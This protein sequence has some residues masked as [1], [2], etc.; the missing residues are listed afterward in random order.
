[1]GTKHLLRWAGAWTCSFISR[2]RPHS[3]LIWL[4]SFSFSM[5]KILS[6]HPRI[7]WTIDTK[8]NLFALKIEALIMAKIKNDRWCVTLY[9][10]IYILWFG[11]M[12]D[13]IDNKTCCKQ[14]LILWQMMS[15]Q[16]SLKLYKIQEWL[17]LNFNKTFHRRNNHFNI[18]ETYKQVLQE[19]EKP[20]KYYADNKKQ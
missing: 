19:S 9:F 4:L 10:T 7:L 2:L 15:Y 5:I 13:F 16:H 12:F 6:C 1:M 17:A 3:H 8:L 20:T 14:F 11:K 18:T